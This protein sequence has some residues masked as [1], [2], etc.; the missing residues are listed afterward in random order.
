MVTGEARSATIPT[1]VAA[2]KARLAPAE[3][4]PVSGRVGFACGQARLASAEARLWSAE[5]RL[6]AAEA[7]H[8]AREKALSSGAMGKTALVTGASAGLGTELAGLFAADGHDVVVVARRRDKLEALAAE[9][10][11]KHQVKVHVL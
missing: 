6:A 1:S 4:R 11:G 9:I 7:R 5:A 3:A 10:Q 2:R 8:G